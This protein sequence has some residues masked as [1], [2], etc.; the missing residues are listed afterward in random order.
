[1][2]KI[3]FVKDHKPRGD[4]PSI[5]SY[6][7][8]ESYDLSSSYAEKYKRL[9]YAVDHVVVPPAIVATA[10]EKDGPEGADGPIGVEGIAL[11]E[12]VTGDVG[13]IEENV[14]PPHRGP[15]KR[16]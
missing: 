9:G 8:G 3:T 2:P 14:R 13:G 1:M 7:A 4:D 11:A 16:R 15:G 6:K 5:P 10:V 12:A